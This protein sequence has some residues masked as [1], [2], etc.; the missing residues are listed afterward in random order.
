M[1]H[2]ALLE[3]STGDNVGFNMKNGDVGLIK[4]IPSKPMV[5]ETF[6]EYPRLGHFAVRDMHQ[7]VVV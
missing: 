3:A 6:S 2:E 5:V 1:Y 4:M 7:T